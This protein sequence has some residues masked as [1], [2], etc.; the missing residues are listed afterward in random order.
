MPCVYADA[1]HAP[2][3]IH[4]VSPDYRQGLQIAVNR[5]GSLGFQKPG[6]LLDEDLTVVARERL[7]TAYRSDLSFS[8]GYTPPIFFTPKRT[9]YDFEVWLKKNSFDCVLTT[10]L[11][12]AC[13]LSPE[14]GPPLFGIHAETKTTHGGLNLQLAEVGRLAVD[15]LRN[16]LARKGR[17]VACMQLVVPPTWTTRWK[18]ADVARWAC[19]S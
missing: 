14:F 7:I 12:Q 19:V 8:G 4:S 17:A 10:D 13:R 9:C 5:L 18:A 3:E 11:E 2:D 16:L 6:L 15:T 1:P